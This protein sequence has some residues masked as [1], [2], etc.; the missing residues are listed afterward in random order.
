MNTQIPKP[1]AEAVVTMLL[2]Y[3]PNLTVEKLE[4]SILETPSPKNQEKLLTRKEAAEALNVS[5]PT[6]D[7][8]LRDEHLPRRKIR[9]AVRIPESATET[10]IKKQD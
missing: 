3:A 4:A 2:P 9:G 10:F 7:R 1:I 6:I 8:M 5:I